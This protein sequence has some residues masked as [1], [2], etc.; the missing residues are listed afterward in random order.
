MPVD[1]LLPKLPQLGTPNLSPLGTPS[2]PSGPKGSNSE[3]LRGLLNNT[4]A[5]RTN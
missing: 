2:L 1:P 3:H 4:S 5:P